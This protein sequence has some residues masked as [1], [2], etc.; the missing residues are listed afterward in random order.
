MFSYYSYER[1][2]ADGVLVALCLPVLVLWVGY[3][4][5]HLIGLVYARY[6]FHRKDH[7]APREE[8]WPGVTILKPL[9][10]CD[11]LLA[12]NLE[13]FFTMNYPTYEIMFCIQN[14]DDPVIP[15]VNELVAKYP[16]ID[17]KVFIGGKKVGTNP[18]I[19]NLQPGYEAG[20]YDLIVVSDS[21]IRMKEDTLMDMVHNMTARVGLVHQM[22]FT[23]DRPGF[24]SVLEKVY[25]GTAHARIYMFAA[26][27]G[28]NCATGMSALMRKG[29]LDEA[30]G[31]PA[32]GCYLAED[33]FFAQT[34]LRK[35][36]QLAVASTPACQIADTKEMVGFQSRLIRWAKLR[37]A[38][39][40]FTILM[41]PVTECLLLGALGALAAR[42]L[43]QV[44]LIVF[45]LVHVLS[46]FML[47]WLM[48]CVV[49]NSSLPFNKFEFVVAWLLRE[50]YA[51]I[52]FLRA[53]WNPKIQW[54]HGVFK[55]RWGGVIEE[56]PTPAP[57]V[58]D[59][60]KVKL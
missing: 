40:P 2:W 60:V 51:P 30:G 38:M 8:P 18:K 1:H 15:L 5:V 13:S 7:L 6:K 50:T 31:L 58:D 19:N 25:F 55:L 3:W 46:W 45:Y 9:I 49:Q 16:K 24:V 44:D 23:A 10:G 47:D 39:V 52:L 22:P 32:F 14:A 33:F 34:F 29:P 42:C 12:A 37:I 4:G 53:I 28:T 41:E 11:A 56:L 59:A 43:L 57:P 35:G 36:Y 20:K 54:R 48:L 26:I 17:T 21:C 27:V